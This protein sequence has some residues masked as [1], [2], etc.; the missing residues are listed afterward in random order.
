[1]SSMYHLQVDTTSTDF[2][3]TSQGCAAQN[4]DCKTQDDQCEVPAECK[5]EKDSK[6]SDG[7][8]P[9]QWSRIGGKLL[10]SVR[11]YSA[12]A[13]LAQLAEQLTLNQSQSA[14]N[15]DTNALSPKGAGAGA[16]VGADSDSFE[17]NWLT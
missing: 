3:T 5:K 9:L 7:C 4:A 11:V 12:S 8:N 17:A 14:K 10:G 6:H 1:M 2:D 13:P 16:A 15:S